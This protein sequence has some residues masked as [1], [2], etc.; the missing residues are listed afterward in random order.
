MVTN[1]EWIFRSVDAGESWHRL[2]G[3]IRTDDV[4]QSIRYSGGWGG[5]GLVP[6]GGGPDFG[7]AT[8]QSNSEGAWMKYTFYGDSITWFAP[9]G[10]EIT[11]IAAVEVD[12][13]DQ[14]TVELWSP[15]NQ[16]QQVVFQKSFRQAGWHTIRITNTGEF[17]VGEPNTW[18]GPIVRSDGFG[19][20]F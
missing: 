2:P 1:H 14:G 11:G 9:K 7:T 16:H 15:G 4:H 5:S 10:P 18:P 20:T 19:V 8:R 17:S 12:G 6:F 3:F 13:R